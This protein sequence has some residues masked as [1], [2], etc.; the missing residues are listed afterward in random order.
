MRN[1][2][3]DRLILRNWRISDLENY[4][5]IASNKKVS[6]LTGFRLKTNKVESLNTLE[7]FIA[8]S[9]DSKWEMKLKELNQLVFGLLN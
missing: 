7:K 6:D 5:K 9:D 1:L 8:V 2:E 4:H 3:S